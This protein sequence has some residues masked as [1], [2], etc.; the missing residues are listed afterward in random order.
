MTF[1]Q[2]LIPQ[3]KC[4]SQILITQGHCVFV[5]NNPIVYARKTLLTRRGRLV[6]AIYMQKWIP[7]DERL[8]FDSQTE[9]SISPD[10]NLEFHA[11]QHLTMS[12]AQEP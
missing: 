10:S 12:E 5:A 8:I 1:L 9:R 4:R 3:A 7:S 11:G 2:D 6:K